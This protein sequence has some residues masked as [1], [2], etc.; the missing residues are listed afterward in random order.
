MMS[1]RQEVICTIEA[2]HNI[3]V[4]MIEF[5]HFLFDDV[6]LEKGSLGEFIE[7]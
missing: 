6:N 1:A 4:T 3:P 2:M 7:T 5:H